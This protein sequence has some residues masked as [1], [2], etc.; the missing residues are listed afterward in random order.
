MTRKRLPRIIT[1]AILAALV[2]AWLI[3]TR[4][5]TL[6]EI[7][8]GLDWEKFEQITVYGTQNWRADTGKAHKVFDQYRYNQDY[9][10]IPIDHE[11]AR[12][13]VELLKA[14]TF[15]RKLSSFFPSGTRYHIT[16]DGDYHWSLMLFGSSGTSLD[17]H[18]RYRGDYNAMG[19]TD[20]E[21]YESEWTDYDLT[22]DKDFAGKV[23]ALITAYIEP[24]INYYGD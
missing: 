7:Y 13:L 8:P 3:F 15:R 6:E 10:S 16:E 20:A 5:M 21:E 19:D 11:L 22:T 18:R 23:F 4:P 2:V 14:Q 12:E 1:L 24:T 9:E 17:L